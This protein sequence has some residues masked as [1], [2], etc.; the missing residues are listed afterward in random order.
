MKMF[1]DALSRRIAAGSLFTLGALLLAMPAT[2]AEKL[3]FGLNWLPQAEMCGFY[4]AQAAGL[5]AK[6]GL[7]VEIVPGGPDR[8]LPLQIAAGDLQLAMGSGFTT[9]NMIQRGIPAQTFAAYLQKDPQTLVAHADQ[10]VET[11]E[12]LKGRPIMIAKF[13]QTEFWQFLKQKY[14]FS[15]SQLRP[16]AYS[17]VPFLANPKAVQQGYITEDAYLLGKDLP[18][19]PVSILLADYGYANY[20]STVY[21]LTR[22]IEA[23]PGLIAAFADASRQGWEECAKGDYSPAMKAVLAANPEHGEALFHFKMKQMRER[24]LIDSGDARLYGPGAMS[25]AHWKE[26]FQSM[27]AA[28][29]YPPDLDYKSAYTLKFSNATQAGAQ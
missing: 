18:K 25:D 19:P 4:Q 21:A 12:D 10:G 6:A 1:A 16:Y 23:H 14:G 2:A 28:G 11:L 27:S 7:D 20:A 9:L 26:F 8:N 3:R 13:S 29:L 24:E 15:D 17:S 5:Y 22:Y